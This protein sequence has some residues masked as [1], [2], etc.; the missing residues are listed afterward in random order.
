MAVNGINGNHVDDLTAEEIEFARAMQAE[1]TPGDWY[2]ESSADAYYRI[3]KSW[4][5]HA[6]VLAE[7]KH[8][9]RWDDTLQKQVVDDGR[10]S[11]TVWNLSA[12]V[13]AV[14]NLSALLNMAERTKKA[15]QAVVDFAG[16]LAVS[17]SD[18]RMSYAEVQVGATAL[19]EF[20]E[21]AEEIKTRR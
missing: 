2:E 14:N 3:V 16:E 8:P 21:L 17:F 7:L 10:K 18:P 19:K 13:W 15:E 9:T 5:D 1:M 20:R 12:V 6:E 11:E 4:P